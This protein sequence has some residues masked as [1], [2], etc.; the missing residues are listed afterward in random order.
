MVKWKE[1]LP[2]FFKD[3]LTGAHKKESGNKKVETPRTKK[4][5]SL[6]KTVRAPFIENSANLEPWPSPKENGM[7]HKWKF[8]LPD[9]HRDVHRQEANHIKRR[10]R[11]SEEN[12]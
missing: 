11:E 8:H 10:G 2:S 4:K 6:N 7:C 1:P 3:V 5:K 9:G 12:I